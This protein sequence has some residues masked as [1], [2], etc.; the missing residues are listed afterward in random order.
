MFETENE[1]LSAIRSRLTEARMLSGQDLPYIHMI[2]EAKVAEK[3]ALPK[4]SLLVI[5]STLSTLLL[6]IFLLALSD[7]VVRD[8]K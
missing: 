4:R 8:G 5:A 6:M 1:N 7:S 3:K 2:N